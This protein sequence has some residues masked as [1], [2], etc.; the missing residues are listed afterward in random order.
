MSTSHDEAMIEKECRG[1]RIKKPKGLIDYKFQH[2]AGKKKRG[3]SNTQLKNS[4]MDL[5]SPVS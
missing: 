4:R 1:L 5:F 2:T 3:G